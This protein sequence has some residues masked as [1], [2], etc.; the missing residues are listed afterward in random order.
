RGDLG[1]TVGRN[2]VH[3]SDSV[4]S[5]ERE[6]N[7]WFKPEEISSYQSPDEVWLYE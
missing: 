6:I 5:A 4:E 3:G 1:L 7:L 2:V